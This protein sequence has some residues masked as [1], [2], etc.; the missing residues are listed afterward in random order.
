MAGMLVK[1]FLDIEITFLVPVVLQQIFLQFLFIHFFSYIYLSFT[2]K[3]K[4]R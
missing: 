3:Q 4:L 2:Q 1:G